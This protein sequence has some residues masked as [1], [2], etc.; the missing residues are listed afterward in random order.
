MMTKIEVKTRRLILRPL[1]L[2]DYDACFD[3]WTK[4]KPAQSKWDPG[5][6]STR[7][8]SKAYYRKFVVRLQKLAKED[9]YYYFGV[10]EKKSGNLI[11]HIDIDIFVRG[12]H[13]FSNF[14]YVL[15]NN[16]WGKGYGQE[17]AKAGLKIGLKYLKLQR[18]EAAIH[19]DNKDSIRLAKGIGMYREGIKKAYWLED[20]I[21]EDHVIYVANPK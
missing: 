13:Q 6:I 10:F 17:S 3:Y 14:G 12:T 20:G 8:C 19:P 5:P 1:T 21:W 11:G 15:N 9:D 2:S 16:Y 18:L 4:R 7:K